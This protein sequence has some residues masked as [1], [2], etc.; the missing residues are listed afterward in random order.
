MPTLQSH[1]GAHLLP[2][3]A[4]PMPITP[5]Y[6]Y[7]WLATNFTMPAAGVQSVSIPVFST[8]FLIEGQLVGVGGAGVMKVHI[9]DGSH[10]QLT[11]P[12]GYGTNSPTGTLIGIGAPLFF[13]P[14]LQEFFDAWNFHRDCSLW[15]CLHVL[16]FNC[17]RYGWGL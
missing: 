12:A 8:N 2:W 13:V 1:A 15:C 5:S 4:D 14:F 9:V 16:D 17:W 6:V 11:N 7:T 3:G 10:V